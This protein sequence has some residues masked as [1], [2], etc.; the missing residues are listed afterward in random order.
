MG[1]QLFPPPKK[2][3]KPPIFSPCLLWPNGWMDQDATWYEGRSQP[4]PHCVGWKPSSPATEMGTQ[5]PTFRPMS[6]M[7]KQSPISATAEQ[8]YWMNA[9]LHQCA[10]TW[11]LNDPL[12]EWIYSVFSMRPTCLARNTTS[13]VVFCS[14]GTNYIQIH[15]SV[16]TSKTKISFVIII[17]L[18]GSHSTWNIIF[19]RW[20]IFLDCIGKYLLTI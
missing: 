12:D 19:H 4:R 16:S 17:I 6:I 3:A 9:A 20:L 1:I 14:G 15:A 10:L 2:G 7:A 13:N 5:L 18:Q 11:Y 8:L